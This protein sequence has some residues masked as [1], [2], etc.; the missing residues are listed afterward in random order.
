MCHLGSGVDRLGCNI[1]VL[2]GSP[3]LDFSIAIP[4]I[5]GIA[6]SYDPDAIPQKSPRGVFREFPPLVTEVFKLELRAFAGSHLEAKA[7]AMLLH[8]VSLSG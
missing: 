8:A 7:L 2:I 4:T 1:R 3:D 6:I 5:E